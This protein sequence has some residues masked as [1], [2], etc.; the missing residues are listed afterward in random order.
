M[1]APYAI[2]GYPSGNNAKTSLPWS[3]ATD[4]LRNITGQVGP[5]GKA[6]IWAITSTVS[7]SGDQGADPNKLVAIVDDVTAKTLPAS[8]KFATLRAAGFAEVLRG[9]SLTPGG[10]SADRGGEHDD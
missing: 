2:A 7:G 5:D 1:G 6:T 9:V 3:P 10:Q 8:E 4:G